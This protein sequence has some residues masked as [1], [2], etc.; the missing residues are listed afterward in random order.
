M[1]NKPPPLVSKKLLE[2]I[3]SQMPEAAV[4]HK[5]SEKGI[6]KHYAY[7]LPEEQRFTDEDVYGA[8]AGMV[9]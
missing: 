8:I 6:V 7:L 2:P 1:F 9:S 4:L 3:L 5:W